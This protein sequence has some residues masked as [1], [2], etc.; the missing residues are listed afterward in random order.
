[1]NNKHPVEERIWAVVAH[2]SAIAMGMGIL[3]PVLG[4]SESRRRSNYAS[5][6]S[7]Q[8]LGYQ[9]LGY[10]IWILT[11]LVV[12]VIVSISSVA[13]IANIVSTEN[14]EA[15]LITFILAHTTLVFGLIGVYFLLPVIAAI[16]CALGRDFRYPIMGNRL[17]KYLGYDLAVSGET[18][19]LIEEHEDRWV[20][21][22]GHFAVII[23]LWGMLAPVTTWIL[24]GKRNMFLKL[25][26]AQTVIFQVG[27]MLLY[28][29]SGFLY[30]GGFIFF[31]LSVGGMEAANL[32]STIGMIGLVVF[33]GS[34]LCTFII[35][36]LVPLLHIMGQWA[37]YRTLKGDDYRYPLV[38][39]WVERWLS[40]SRKMTEV[41]GLD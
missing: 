36:L 37:G 8:A 14:F 28:F 30:I 7:L 39:K 19:W 26:S 32:D 27:T 20:A 24:Q 2:L 22:M 25:Q 31:L 9:S 17:A 16:S 21:S 3:L 41:V 5:F 6:Q 18:E 35:V 15:E 13:G 10:T 1:M 11:T 23:M 4:W 34:L 40:K 33:F 29:L 38:G 12:V